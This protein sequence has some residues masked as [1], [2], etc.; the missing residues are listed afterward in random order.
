VREV[1]DS[2]F[3]EERADWRRVISCS[4]MARSLYRREEKAE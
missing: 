1:K 4:R 3:C 2:A